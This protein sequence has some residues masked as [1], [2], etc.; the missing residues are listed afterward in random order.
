[1]FVRLTRVQN[2]LDR[3]DDGIANYQ[4]QLLPRARDLPGFEGAV[5][6]VDRT[7]G[8]GVSV[9]YW[10]SEE[11]LRASEQGAETLRTQ[12]SQ[13]TGATVRDIDRFELV[14][15]ER[16]APPQANTF[17]RINDVRS[18]PDKMDPM[19][20]FA[21]EQVLPTIRNQPGCRAGILG[22]N[23]QSGRMFL[24]SVWATAADRE[25]SEAAVREQRRQG[26]QI[27]GTDQVQV[28]LY[29]VAVAEVSQAVLAGT[30]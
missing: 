6:L 3:L 9:T 13:T 22:V 24:A 11:A 20:Q 7:S 4:Q 18:T 26:G 25:A 1:M 5:L 10:E 27:A 21:R 23:R 19:I 29:E 16:T 28:E 12:A 15:V 2:Q 17:V 30:P 8:A 14:L